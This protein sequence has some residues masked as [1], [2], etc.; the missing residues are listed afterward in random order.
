[1]NN[2]SNFL[3]TI[4]VVLI[5]V[6]VVE[7]AYFFY[8]QPQ[9]QK[10][11]I[12]NSNTAIPNQALPDDGS[13][14]I[15]R[16]QIVYLKSLKKISADYLK[17]FYSMGGIGTVSNL[18]KITPNQIAFDITDE[19]GKKSTNIRFPIVENIPFQIY[20]SENGVIAKA[21]LGDLIEGD[22]IKFLWIYDLS[23]P[24]GKDDA[25]N[26]ELIIYKNKG[27]KIY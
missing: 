5:V 24:P 6:A 7:L 12:N 15:N 22:K 13:F 8:F 11:K 21:S 17:A 23:K 14:V 4:F 27:E 25:Y 20:K 18:K 10:T 2:S 3:K 1:M 16:E 9:I 26:N 19:N